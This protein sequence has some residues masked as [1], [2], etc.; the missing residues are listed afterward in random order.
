M[1]SG[2]RLERAVLDYA[3]EELNQ[4]VLAGPFLRDPKLP[5]GGHLDGV[6]ESGDVVEAKTSRSKR[7][8][9]EPGTD[10][11]PLSYVVQCQHYLGLMPT[12]GVAWVPVL[13][14]G[15]DFALYRVE[16]DDATI[17]SMREI[18]AEWW[19]VHVEGD[20][21]P[22]PVNGAD[23]ARLFPRDTGI[24]VVADDAVAE[25]VERLRA[26][27]AQTSDLEE[28]REALEDRIKLAM[29][30]AATLL[31]NGEPAVTWRHTKPSNRFDASAFKAA[32][33]TV[34]AEFCRPIEKRRFLVKT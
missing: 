9:G 23:A 6:T 3:A 26:I 12:A 17:Q 22:P 21:P 1:R 10:A 27:K 25:A 28:A 33:P 7:D 31:V 4:P 32:Q 14:S 34:Y 18:C 19:R 8:W 5:L 2:L 15:L 16:R 20:T 11:I 24:A 13:F 29:G 30:P